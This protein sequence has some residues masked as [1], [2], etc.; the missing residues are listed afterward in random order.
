MKKTPQEGGCWYCHEDTSPL[1]FSTE[2]DTYVHEDC[3]RSQTNPTSEDRIMYNELLKD[4]D[5]HL[6]P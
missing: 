3:I 1:L 4:I 5:D 6:E 2:F